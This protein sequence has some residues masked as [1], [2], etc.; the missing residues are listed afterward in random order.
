M[1]P[2]EIPFLAAN[3]IFTIAVL[4]NLHA[5]FS[6]WK[7]IKGFDAFSKIGAT[8]TFVALLFM[9]TGYIFIN[10]YVNV[11]MTVPTILYWGLISYKKL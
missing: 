8:S 10:S 3:I 9:T 6:N 1:E 7:N 11:A 4:P 5:I 2:F